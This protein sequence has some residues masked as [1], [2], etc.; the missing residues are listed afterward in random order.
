MRFVGYVSPLDLR[1]LYRLARFL[2]F[3]SLFEGGG[4]PVFEAF[5]AGVPVAC[6]NVTCLPRQAGDAALLFEP[7]DRAAMADALVRT[8]GDGALRSDLV[9]RGRD[10]VARFT[11]DRT[12]RIYRAHY[13]QIAG[14]TLGEEDRALLDAPPDT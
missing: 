3:P 1:C 6:S 13:R 4:M 14:R 5:A 9:R 12:A 7:R 11:W 2:V 8:W 10:R